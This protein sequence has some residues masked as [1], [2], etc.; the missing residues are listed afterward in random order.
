MVRK[1]RQNKLINHYQKY[2]NSEYLSSSKIKSR[3]IFRSNNIEKKSLI[4]N[5]TIDEIKNNLSNLSNYHDI[6]EFGKT[7]FSSSKHDLFQRIIELNNV[8]EDEE[9]GDISIES[10]KS[11]LLF[12]FCLNQFNQPTIT[13]NDLGIFQTRWKKD[14]NN[15]LTTSFIENWSL[16]YVLFLPSEYTDDRIIL[17]GAM[18]VLDFVGYLLKINCQVYQEK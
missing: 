16:N 10:L 9:D 15:L 1:M 4:H 8:F 3:C 17:N 2:Y 7:I 12:L 5:L 13:L 6:I 11:M 18:N 14:R